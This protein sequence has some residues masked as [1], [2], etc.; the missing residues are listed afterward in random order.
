M[1]TF[2]HMGVPYSRYGIVKEGA[3]TI[4]WMRV[5]D[6]QN[7]NDHVCCSSVGFLLVGNVGQNINPGVVGVQQM[8]NR[9][10]T[11]LFDLNKTGHERN[12]AVIPTLNGMTFHLVAKHSSIDLRMSIRCV[13]IK[14]ISRWLWFNGTCAAPQNQTS[15]QDG[16]SR[17]ERVKMKCH[18]CSFHYEKLMMTITRYHS[19]NH[20]AR[21]LRGAM[22]I[23]T[24]ITLITTMMAK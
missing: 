22:N 3:E 13:H 24:A 17:A 8:L 10:V 14:R 9:L 2:L 15:S 5:I 4:L 19:F 20:L 21:Y 11:C 16:Q 7:V 23:T 18:G 6:V 1:G 12:V